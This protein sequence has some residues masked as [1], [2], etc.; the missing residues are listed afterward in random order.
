MSVQAAVNGAQRDM[1]LYAGINGA[2]RALFSVGG[3]RDSVGVSGSEAGIQAKVPFDVSEYSLIIAVA[4]ES[5]SN[6]AAAMMICFPQDKL[7]T[8]LRFRSSSMSAPTALKSAEIVIGGI[9][10]GFTYNPEDNTVK[11]DHSSILDDIRLYL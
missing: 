11:A 5:L 8:T 1:G 7:A 9:G 3:I 4:D 10:R 2:V 6:W